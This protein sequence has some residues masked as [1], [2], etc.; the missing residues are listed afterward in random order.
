MKGLALRPYQTAMCR[1][2]TD[3]WARGMMRPAA[4]LPTGG[5]KTVTVSKIIGDK[6][7]EGLGRTVVLVHRPELVNQWVSTLRLQAPVLRTGVVQASIDQT[8]ADVVVAMVQ[9]ARSAARMK[10]IRNVGLVVVD[11]CHHAMA[12]SYLDILGHF[13]CLEGTVAPSGMR[14]RALGVTATMSR[15]DGRGLG[16]VWEDV[17]HRTPIAHLIR[18]GYL[19]EPYGIAVRVEDLDL[20]RVRKAKGGDY[21]DAALG[22]AMTASMAPKRIL[23]AWQEHGSGRLTM[24]FAPTVEFARL[25]VDE[26]AAAG[27]TSALVWG[28]MARVDR[29][30]VLADFAARKVQVV[31]NFGVLTEGTDIPPVDCI[32]VARRTTYAGLYVQMVG[33]GL[34]LAPGKTDCLVLDVAGASKRHALTTQVDLIGTE[35]VAETT[36][37]DGINLLDLLESDLHEG[38]PGDVLEQSFQDGTIVAEHIDLFHGSRLAWHQTRAG[39]WF[40]PVGNRYLSIVPDGQ[41]HG[42]VAR[43]SFV[44]GRSWWVARGLPDQSLAMAMAEQEVTEGEREVAARDARYR[45]RPPNHY[46]LRAWLRRNPMHQAPPATVGE[47]RRLQVVGDASDALDPGY[48]AWLANQQ[49]AR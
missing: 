15:G 40:L 12:T 2:V 43:E 26:F 24:G 32:I 19:V 21:Q 37:D 30:Q 31:W 25:M 6:H 41:G 38:A 8:G 7:A 5:G 10:R 28:E 48:R 4:V 39:M 1:A 35:D 23:E 20:A 49:V 36:E 45:S 3:A 14:A 13:G 27:I 29:E 17:V 47:L 33:R 11:E 16:E 18:D 42:V 22:A 34:R 46:E 9:T 44:N